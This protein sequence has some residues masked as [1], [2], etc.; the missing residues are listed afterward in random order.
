MRRAGGSSAVMADRARGEVAADTAAEAIF[1]RIEYFPTPPWAARAGGELI[2]ALDPWS[3]PGDARAPGWR[4]WEPA[5]GGG[6]MAH[7]LAPYFASVHATD[8]FDHAWPGRHGEPL[9][10]LSPEADRLAEHLAVDWIVT[11]PPFGAAAEFV[12]AGLRRA[13]RGV[14]ILARSVLLEGA[15]RFSMFHG[16]ETRL[17]AFAPFSERV[18]MA[19]GRWDPAAS[20]ATAYAWFVWL[21][22]GV[23]PGPGAL[24]PEIWPI[25]PGTRARLTRP[26][27]ARLFGAARPAPL[28]GALG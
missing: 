10:F 21:K 27:D 3:G 2:A 26:D 14:A 25:G 20:T 9:D 12:A 6:H 15:S 5:C 16:P 13:R 17:S 19:L 22:P 23:G 28:F 1:R 24:R 8:V 18:P 7:G 11:N 4:A